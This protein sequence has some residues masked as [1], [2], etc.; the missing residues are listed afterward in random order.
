ML[1]SF[2][3][4]Q[5]IITTYAVHRFSIRLVVF[6]LSFRLQI[7]STL[8]GEILR[9]SAL[10]LVHAMV[11]L[12][13]SLQT[14]WLQDLPARPSPIPHD[15][16]VL[17]DFPAMMQHVLQKTNV[18]PALGALRS[19]VSNFYYS[20]TPDAPCSSHRE[21]IYPLGFSS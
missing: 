10:A 18:Q 4:T 14:V 15:P 12:I 20:L 19:D 21:H 2:L 11:Q 3:W 7:S 5:E 8:T 1:V 13:V 16:K 17:D 6:V 9:T